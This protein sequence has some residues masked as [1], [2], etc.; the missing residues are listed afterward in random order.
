MLG[1]ALTPSRRIGYTAFLYLRLA[2]LSLL[3][4]LILVGSVLT[5]SAGAAEPSGGQAGAGAHAYTEV[6]EGARPPDAGPPERATPPA[7]GREAP[8]GVSPVPTPQEAHEIVPAPAPEEAKEVVP[9][10]PAPEEAHEVVPAPAPEEAKEVVPPAPAS[11]EAQAVVLTGPSTEGASESSLSPLPAN[12][13]SSATRNGTSEEAAPPGAPSALIESLAAPSTI[14]APAEA[15]ASPNVAVAS[16]SVAAAAIA[17]QRVQQLTCE[18]SAVGGRMTDSCTAGST[19]TQRFQSASH[20]SFATDVASLA[21]ATGDAPPGGGHGGS[22]SG[23]PPVTP[24]PGPAPGGASGSATGAS[25]F[26]LSGF[27]TLAGLLLLGAPR[28]LRR[29]RLSCQPWRT[30]CFALIPERPG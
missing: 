15:A 14:L 17:A 30:A 5:Q 18:L 8:E 29:L 7:A 27:F 22:A 2:M 1:T 13:Q 25:G 19:A 23:S 9:P 28:A 11:E 24:T 12:A 26:A 16:A 4:V 20:T 3:G 21:A 6:A 10:G